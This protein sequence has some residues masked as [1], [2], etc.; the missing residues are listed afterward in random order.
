MGLSVEPIAGSLGAIVHGV[1]AARPLNDDALT[2]LR[3][4]LLEHLVVFLPD[5]AL[6][7]DG[8]ERLTDELGGRDI[9]PYVRPV[10][11]R[12]YV[13]RVIKEP[14]DEI[15][16]AN[17]WHSDLSY[18][19]TPPSFTVLHARTVPP[20]GGDTM[21]ANQYLAYEMMPDTLKERLL[22]M[23]AS[24]SAGFAYGTGGY[25]ESV[26]DKSS[27]QIEPSA[28]AHG[29][30]RHP[31]V[32]RHPETGRLALYVNPTYTTAI[33]DMDPME[34][35]QLLDRLFRHS[36]HENLTCRI[37]WTP[38]M[39]AIWD[40]RCTQHIAINDYAGHRREMFRTSVRGAVPVGPI[41]EHV[42]AR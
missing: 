15:N 40:N 21:W 23:H 42:P 24:H 1:D 38:N 13:I 17:A 22:T 25:L 20:F 2:Q 32:I 14:H 27:M 3:G 28:Q 31:V 30:Q 37:R 18:A 6:D 34:S 39:V 16:F 12:P 33:D 10:D 4:A 35:R 19:A 5:Q 36:V 9:T 41:N 7:L 29:T 8:L 11:G 26:A